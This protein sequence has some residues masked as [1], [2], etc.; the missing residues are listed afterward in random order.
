[1]ASSEFNIFLQIR[2]IQH[3]P[4]F[5]NTFIMI[6]S[7]IARERIW[8]TS[9]LLKTNL[10][11]YENASQFDSPMNQNNQSCF[12]CRRMLYYTDWQEMLNSEESIVVEPAPILSPFIHM[13]LLQLQ[14]GENAQILVVFKIL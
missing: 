12:Y 3:S 9:S 8:W 4:T 10:Y 13:Q 14:C 1:M 7:A 11:K 5:E 2:I 6:L